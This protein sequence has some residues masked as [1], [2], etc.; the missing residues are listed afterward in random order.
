MKASPV[1]VFG[2]LMSV[3]WV[4]MVAGVL[5]VFSGHLGSTRHNHLPAVEDRQQTYDVQLNV[6]DVSTTGAASP[7]C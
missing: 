1:A 5:S 6:C 7:G 4:L 3:G 2:V